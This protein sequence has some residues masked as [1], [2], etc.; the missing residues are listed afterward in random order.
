MRYLVTILILIVATQFSYSQ[1]LEP[2]SLTNLPTGTNFIV[3]AYG[4]TSGDISHINEGI[5]SVDFDQNTFLLGYLRS[6]NLFGLASKISVLLP[7][8]S[9]NYSANLHGDFQSFKFSGISDPRLV[10]SVNFFGSPVQKLSEFKD[11]KPNTI[12]GFSLNIRAPL[13]QY[14]KQYFI[15]PGKNN[16]AF[17][18]QIGISKY[19]GKWI[20]EAYFST[21]FETPNTEWLGD[22]KKEFKPLFAMKVHV[23]RTLKRNS[24]V[25]LDLG[26]GNG[27]K[28]T[29]DDVLREDPISTI[30]MGAT[31]AKPITPKHTLKLSGYTDLR[32]E[33][34]NDFNSIVLSYQYRWFSKD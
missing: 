11:Y 30:R 20:I 7:Y 2:R 1:Q 25:T 15:N 27:G 9:G 31:F 34:K 14:E 28:T 23:I 26:Y 16:W 17:R 8:V 3:G 21:L 22:G 29:L 18:P 19:K 32:F 10:L 12:A 6:I 5:S 33:Y 24:W 13:G 4:Y